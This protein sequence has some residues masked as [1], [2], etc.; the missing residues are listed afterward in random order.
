MA[1]K[2]IVDSERCKGCGLCVSV[3]PKNV[4]EITGIVNAKGHF[5]VYQARP[6]DCIHC[7]MCCI[8]C[9]DVAISIVETQKQPA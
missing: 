4:L 2:H 3:C 9:P 5:P 8:M 1:Y 6:D 7:T